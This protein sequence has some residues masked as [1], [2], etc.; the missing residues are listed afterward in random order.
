VK[1][2]CKIQRGNDSQGERKMGLGFRTIPTGGVAAPPYT[3]GPYQ[4]SEDITFA[5]ASMGS[6]G[7]GASWYVDGTNGASTNDAKSWSTAIDTIQGAIDLA[8]AGD[9][10]YVTSQ[11]ITDFTGD[12]TSYAE[13][14]TITAGLNNLSII[15]V[16]RGRTQGGLPQLKV[17]STTTQ[18]L[19]TV[20]AAGC[21]ILNMGLNG[22]GATGGGILLDDDNSTTT[23]FGTTIASCHFKN[24]VGTTATNAATGGAI[25][26]STEGNAWQVLISGNRFYKNV[27]DI[28]LLGTSNSVPQDVVIENN[29]FSGPAANTDCNLYLK[30]GSGMNGVVIKNNTFSAI[31]A[32]GS[33]TNHQCLALT[34]CVGIMAGNLFAATTAEGETERTFGAAGDELVPVTVFMAA[35][36]GEF[37]TGVGAGLISGEIFRT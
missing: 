12:P 31:P 14:V 37:G 20:N 22:I 11:L 8:G 5:N 24:C 34:G 30:G 18:A 10:V 15:G 33:A 17:G 9:T 36:Y 13:N 32:I 2:L 3:N 28:V 6:G 7:E 16:S 29:D 26:W 4:F 25:Q 27:G 35:N 21:L 19:L 1:A 23:A